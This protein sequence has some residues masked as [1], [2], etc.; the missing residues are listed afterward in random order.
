[1]AIHLICDEWT[2]QQDV[3]A[4]ESIKAIMVLE[5]R[6]RE[7]APGMTYSLY[8]VLSL[9][10]CGSSGSELGLLSFR[11]RP[12][13]QNGQWLVKQ[14]VARSALDFVERNTCHYSTHPP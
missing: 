6:P 1:M 2:V 9:D 7:E 13:R 11:R 8:K 12:N 14:Y 5:S 10:T 3:G 4:S